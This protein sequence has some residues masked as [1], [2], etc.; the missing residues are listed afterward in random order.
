MSLGNSCRFTGRLGQDPDLQYTPAGMAIVKV[1][2]AVKD[3]RKKDEE[4]VDETTWVNLTVFG[5][6]AETLAQ[7]CNKGDLVQVD[8]QY[9]TSTYEVDGETKYRHDFIVREWSLAARKGE[10]QSANEDVEPQE[11]D[12]QEDDL[13]F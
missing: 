11:S 10:P 4:W 1:G 12:D 5:K 7:V 13:P 8:T 6:K 3:R 2:I 9:Q